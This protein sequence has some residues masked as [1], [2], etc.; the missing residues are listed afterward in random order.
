MDE[1]I[2]K[3][4]YSATRREEVLPF[5]TTW[6]ELTGSALSEVTQTEKDEYHMTPIY[7]WNRKRKKETQASEL[8]G[9]ENR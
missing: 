6:M 5:A 3:G 7:M 4:Y 1:R 9:T 2:R 8:T